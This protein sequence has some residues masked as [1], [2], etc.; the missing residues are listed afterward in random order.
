MKIGDRVK[1]KRHRCGIDTIGPFEAVVE[2]INSSDYTIE[3]TDPKGR[4]WVVSIDK[5]QNEN[6]PSCS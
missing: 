1:I 5:V 2:W 4:D 3:V 6:V